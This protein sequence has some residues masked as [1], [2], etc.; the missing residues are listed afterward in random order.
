M[1]WSE[2][3]RPRS[4]AD[5]VGN[6]EARAA[7]VGWLEGWKRGAR[8]LLLVGP[9]G[10][11]K[12]TVAGLACREFGYDMVGLNASDARGRSRIGGVLGPVLGSAGMAGSPMIFVDE[13]DGIHGRADFGGAEALLKI[14]K[15]PAVPIVMAA[16]SA[17]SDK[18]RAIKKASAV[19]EFRPVPP[20]LMRLHLRRVLAEEGASLSPG[21]EIRAVGQ[22][23]GDMR[24]MLNAAQSLA[25][26]FST[27]PEGPPARL[28]AGECVEA[29]FRAGTAAE[30]R[31]VLR[32]ARADPREKIGAFYSSIVTSGLPPADMAAMLRAVSDADVLHGRIL[33]TQQWRLLRYLDAA[34]AGAHR[35]GARVAYS[36]YDLPWPLLSRIRWDGRALRAAM[37][38]LGGRMH[39]S[40]SRFSTFC[41]PFM[42]CCIRNGAL[43]PD[44]DEEVS[45]ALEKE[46][47]RAG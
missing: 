32:S 37:T 16:N 10:T 3:H 7:V 11:G 28:G 36:R 27:A 8:P 30:A 35:K 25:T 9:P 38:R 21:A 34:L 46:A 17:S 31:A 47:G 20:R 33:R 44:P 5:M 2:R 42:L 18:M 6:E 14:L 24:S 29:F 40:R 19:V 22:S 39:V 23:R 12:T 13:V 43:A 4:I 26:G 15:D 41:L 1:M 45:A